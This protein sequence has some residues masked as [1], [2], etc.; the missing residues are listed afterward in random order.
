MVF[1]VVTSLQH[2]RVQIPGDDF[3]ATT[4]FWNKTLAKQILPVTSNSVHAVMNSC[5]PL[6]VFLSLE[7]YQITDLACSM[8]LKF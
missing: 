2:S 6:P 5:V 1:S 4:Y 8:T 7:T 3:F